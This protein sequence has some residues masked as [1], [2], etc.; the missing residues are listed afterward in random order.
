MSVG[1]F[2][3]DSSV[4]P[5]EGQE[6]SGPDHRVDP[7]LPQLRNRRLLSDHQQE[8]A[9]QAGEGDQDLHRAAVQRRNFPLQ[10]K[11]K[12]MT[13]RVEDM[14]TTVKKPPKNPTSLTFFPCV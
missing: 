13:S 1:D 10:G 5:P 6:V 9:V 14:K 3:C 12:M 2:P 7:V 8:P 11:V 4:E